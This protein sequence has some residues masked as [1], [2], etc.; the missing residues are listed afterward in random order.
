MSSTGPGGTWTSTAVAGNPRRV[1]RGGASRP[2][3]GRCWGVDRVEDP[4]HG[5]I[6]GHRP[7]QCSLVTEPGRIGDGLT[8]VGEHHDR[9]HGDPARIVPAL[10]LPQPG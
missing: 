2:Q 1:P 8:P 7:E 9:G 4:P 6:A 10:P 5:R 3:P